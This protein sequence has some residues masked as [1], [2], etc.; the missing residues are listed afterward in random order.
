[1][2]SLADHDRD[3]EML[4]GTVLLG[5]RLA[6]CGAVG[7]EHGLSGGG[8]KEVG[9]VGVGPARAASDLRRPGDCSRL[10]DGLWRARDIP[11][12]RRTRHRVVV[13]KD[14]PDRIAA[15]HVECL[16]GIGLV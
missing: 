5:H 2:R 1:M 15:A 8:R 13:G 16:A 6:G 3:R 14:D 7:A 12:E 4:I 9:R 11:L 10:E